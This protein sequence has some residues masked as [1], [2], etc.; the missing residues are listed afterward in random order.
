MNAEERAG[1]LLSHPLQSRPQSLFARA[2]LV[3]GDGNQ[4]YH[5]T[6]PAV[7][8]IF[9]AEGA[10][11]IEFAQSGLKPTDQSLPNEDGIQWHVWS[12]GDGGGKKYADGWSALMIAKLERDH[13]TSLP[14]L[15]RTLCIVQ[16]LMTFIIGGEIRIM[17]R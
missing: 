9:D 16:D 5:R 10:K 2:L 11:V 1:A 15:D 3:E 8:F 13:L 12:D 7:R 4:R 17:S 6:G 14:A